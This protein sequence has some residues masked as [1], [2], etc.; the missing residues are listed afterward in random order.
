MSPNFQTLAAEGEA[1]PVLVPKLRFPEF[2]ETE[3]WE[4]KMLGRLCRI[5]TV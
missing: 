4:T 1:K 5:R 3:G 2:R